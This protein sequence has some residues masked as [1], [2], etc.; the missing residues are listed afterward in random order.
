MCIASLCLLSMY[1]SIHLYIYRIS[2][3]P[4]QPW[5]VWDLA[6]LPAHLLLL[7][8]RGPDEGGGR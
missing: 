8:L 5:S 6:A 7:L 3:G 1:I 4:D 2:K